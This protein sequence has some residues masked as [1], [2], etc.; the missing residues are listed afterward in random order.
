MK[1]QAVSQFDSIRRMEHSQVVQLVQSWVP[2]MRAGDPGAVLLEKASA[3]RN[4]KTGGEMSV[5]ILE[6]CAQTFNQGIVLQ[7]MKD[8]ER[9]GDQELIKIDQL[10]ADYVTA[11]KSAAAP[12]IVAPLPATRSFAVPDIRFAILHP[13]ALEKAATVPQPPAAV[14]TPP[15]DPELY[16]QCAAEARADLFSK[17]AT[18]ERHLLSTGH[19]EQM[20]R[21]AN[22]SSFGRI[23][24]D[25]IRIHPSRAKAAALWLEDYWK[26]S[27]LQVAVRRADHVDMER[28]K[29]AHDFTGEAATMLEIGD[30]VQIWH[31]AGEMAKQAAWDMQK[32]YEENPTF[33]RPKNPNP[34][35]QQSGGTDSNQG[36]GPAPKNPGGKQKPGGTPNNPKAG[37]L[38]MT[39]F[40][41]VATPEK[42]EKSEKPDPIVRGGIAKALGP[43][44]FITGGDMGG[45]AP[46]K[47][48]NKGQQRVDEAAEQVQQITNLQRLLVSDPVISK[49]DPDTVARIYTTILNTSPHVASD[50]GLLHFQMR[51]M[52]QYGGVPIDS[53]KQLA[54][55]ENAVQDV[56]E[57]KRQEDNQR[58][59]PKSAP[60]PKDKAAA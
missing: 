5:A 49:A 52:L 17:L 37:P 44:K 39:F 40:S 8:G 50:P 60:K 45:Y 47:T 42:P 9:G 46:G 16:L 3:W 13:Q 35:R 59:G 38:P 11:P 32:F 15:D 28:H 27:P 1:L 2:A 20:G 22:L 30:L 6:K 51:E 33:A 21:G 41:G 57:G 43:L 4:P 31:T 14:P 19:M 56:R 24:A 36:G 10:V 29:L 7:G 12:V 53:A 34:E 48:Y 55:T 26:Q 23:E 54:Q 18:W 58:Y 25:A